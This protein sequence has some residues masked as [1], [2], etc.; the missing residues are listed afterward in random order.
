MLFTITSSTGGSPTDCAAGP[1]D[2]RP[3]NPPRG[4]ADARY[5]ESGHLVY[6][7][8][9]V[10]QAV[11]FDLSTRTIAGT[12]VPVLQQFAMLGGVQRCLT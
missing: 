11:P 12:P 4:G 10:L 5:V 6:A 8:N 9:G 1:R 2:R 7:A 3:E